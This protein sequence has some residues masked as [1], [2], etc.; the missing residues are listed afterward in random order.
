M[1]PEEAV[2]LQNRLQEFKS[3]EHR[4]TLVDKIL[5]ALEDGSVDNVIIDLKLKT[6]R[7]NREMRKPEGFTICT[8][9]NAT[10]VRF[11]DAFIAFAKAEAQKLKDE[12]EL[13][14]KNA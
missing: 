1:T 13:R 6:V 8:L 12:L 7:Y 3:A 4:S 5:D 9:D 11:C 2:E 10:E 14:K